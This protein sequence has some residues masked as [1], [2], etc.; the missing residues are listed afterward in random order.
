MSKQEL[1]YPDRSNLYPFDATCGQIVR[2][3]E[4]R[5]WQIQG[6][7]VRLNDEGTEV[8]TIEGNNFRLYF[9]RNQGRIGDEEPDLAAVSQLNIPGQEL[10]VY[11]DFSGPTYYRYIGAD[12]ET[13][14]EKFVHGSKFLSK[15]H[16]EPRTYLKYE[17]SWD[18]TRHIDR[19]EV[20][21]NTDVYIPWLGSPIY[22]RPSFIVP[23]L[24]HSNDWYR[25]YDLEPDDNPYYITWQVVREFDQWLHDN[26]LKPN[27]R[28]AN[29]GG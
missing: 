19:F 20:I 5:N 11:S 21:G 15:S 23:Y 22:R 12:W 16:G 27:S 17:G 18:S 24:V 2:S 10:H 14:R 4:A 1:H 8:K 3:L 9:C 28:F 29:L 13:D 26:I 6:I 7:Q 25:E